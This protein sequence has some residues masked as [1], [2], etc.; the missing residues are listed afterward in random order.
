MIYHIFSTYFLTV[1]SI[2]YLYKMWKSLNRWFLHYKNL[3]ILSVILQIKNLAMQTIYILC[4]VPVHNITSSRRNHRLKWPCHE[5]F[6][7]F[8]ISWIKPIWPIDKQVKRWFS[9]KI[10]FRGGICEIIDLV[11]V[12]T[13]QSQ[14]NKFEKF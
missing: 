4:T 5:I 13:V 14:K 12:N 1:Y 3:F 2:Y 11:Q 7:H 9:L 6:W 8:F 10:R